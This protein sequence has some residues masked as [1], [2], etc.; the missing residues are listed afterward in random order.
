MHP[1]FI[2]ILLLELHPESLVLY[3][4]L[5]T[6]PNLP[7]FLNPNNVLN[8]L[9]LPRYP[10]ENG[11]KNLWRLLQYLH[12]THDMALHLNSEGLNI[13]YWW[14]N[15]SY[16]VHNYLKGP[17]RATLSIL[18]GCVTRM[19]KKHNINTTSCNQGGVL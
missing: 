8:T 16:G 14:V 19:S 15:T 1:H 2:Y 5:D 18:R 9:I 6:I 11:W 10:D 17:T 3:S 7:N 4:F 13:I 12:G